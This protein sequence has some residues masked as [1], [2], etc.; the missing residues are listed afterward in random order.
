MSKVFRKSVICIAVVLATTNAAI[1]KSINSGDLSNVNIPSVFK[2]LLSSGMPIVAKVKY[3]GNKSE[4]AKLEGVI[5]GNI[6]LKNNELILSY[7]DVKDD[8]VFS[9]EFISELKKLSNISFDKKGNIKVNNNSYLNINVSKMDLSLFVD[10]NAFGKKAKKRELQIGSSSVDNITSLMNYDFGVSTS[11][12]DNTNY[13]NSYLN[14]NTITGMGENHLIF[15][16]SIFGI[17][18]SD[19]TADLRRVLYERD[20]DG[21]RFAFGILSGWDLQSLG[22]VNALQPK[23]I[24]GFSYGNKSNSIQIDSSK[25]YNPIFVFLPSQGEVRIYKN[26]RLISIQNFGMGNHEVDTTSFPSGNYTVTAEVVIN[27]KI[28]SSNKYKVNKASY[29]KGFSKEPSW[30]IWGG[31]MEPF[32]HYEDGKDI[33]NDP[34]YLIGISNSLSFEKNYITSSFYS[35]DNNF[36]S[37]VQVQSE[38][39][40]WLE[41]T[42]QVLFATDGSWQTLNTATINLFKYGTIWGSFE[43]SRYGKKINENDEDSYGYGGNINLNAINEH[44]GNVSF[45]RQVDKDIKSDYTTIS[46]YQHL[47]TGEYGS[48]SLKLDYYFNKFEFYSED[49]KSISL[50]YNVPLGSRFRAG[51]SNDAMGNVSA[52]LSYDEVNFNEYLPAF[53]FSL[54]SQLEGEHDIYASTYLNYNTDYLD[55]S[56]NMSRSADNSYSLNLSG[57]GSAGI[58]NN[59]V[60]ISNNNSGDSG[61][62]I[63]SNLDNNESIEAVIDGQRY[64]VQGKQTLIPLN[65]YKEYKIQLDNDVNVKN[66]YEIK[67]KERSLTL[68]PGNLYTYD[69]SESV[70]EMITV[71]GV[72]KDNKGN[73]L[74]N[75]KAHNHIGTTVTDNEGNFVID[76]NK[77][78]PIVT[79]KNHEGAEC[80]ADLDIKDGVGAVW[81]GDTICKGK[82]SYAKN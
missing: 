75:T 64:K 16:A 42:N 56:I 32:D 49:E 43:Q 70:V 36:L 44:L 73:T 37:E 67:D 11:W 53:G 61:I 46:Y 14:I 80:E 2:D 19:Q 21:K 5:E 65:G 8:K 22:Q 12:S 66:S 81:I 6:F 13:S 30:Q 27:G 50:E 60:A 7:V 72:L 24:W 35:F 10:K 51:I 78:F 1:A 45:S 34:T 58:S 23:R 28:E 69:I 57:R 71:F 26:S 76:V 62:I 79:S 74:K 77:N 68:Y 47:Y 38:I 48:L 59:G 41:L 20:Q 63:K 17:G 52:D 39:T 33:I 18:N 54:S 31:F 4:D 29:A 15:D 9:N 82:E 3:I 25:S 40:D 55:G